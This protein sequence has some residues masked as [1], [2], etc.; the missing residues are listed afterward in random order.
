M[1]IKK[2][3][4]PDRKGEVTYTYY[5]LVHSYKVGNK[6]RQ[7]TIIDKDDMFLHIKSHQKQLKEQSMEDKIKAR[8]IESMDSLIDGSVKA[9]KNEKNYPGTRESR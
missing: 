1:F 6:N 9:P 8:F 4:K 5:R 2:I 3:T 7:Q